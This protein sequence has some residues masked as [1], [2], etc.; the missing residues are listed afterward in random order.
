M[1]I[2]SHFSAGTLK[3]KP[4][5]FKR[6]LFMESWIIENKDILNFNPRIDG[7][8]AILDWEVPISNGRNKKDGTQ[9][10]GRIDIVARYGDD[11]I[12]V[13]E[14]KLE[15]ADT[16][17]EEQL[18]GYLNQKEEIIKELSKNESFGNEFKDKLPSDFSWVGILCAE[19]ISH[20]IIDKIENYNKIGEDEFRAISVKRF[21]NEENG[22]IF[23][24]TDCYYEEAKS[25]KNKQKVIFDNDDSM[26]YAKRNAV[27]EAVK[28]Y[29]DKTTPE[30]GKLVEAFPNQ[31]NKTYGVIKPVKEIPSDRNIRYFPDEIL[32]KNNISIRVCNQW[33]IGN[34]EAFIENANKLGIKMKLL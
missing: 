2:Y 30:Y 22:Q 20:D 27:L 1:N 7:D 15:N 5:P 23:V 18:S 6:E 32:L 29:V 34:I 16:K 4:F 14:L 25:N 21:K 3:T 28:R 24:L 31:L 8:V 17:A 12:A 13:I 19:K 11:I 9:G 10:D 33:G 26:R